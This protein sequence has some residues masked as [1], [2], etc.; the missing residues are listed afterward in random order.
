MAMDEDLLELA[1]AAAAFVAAH[2][3]PA[4][5]D[6]RRAM[7]AAVGAVPFRV[8]YSL[9][10]AGLLMWLIAAYAGAPFVEI[11]R[12]PMALLHLPLTL[13]L[14]ACVLLVA[15]F[16]AAPMKNLIVEWADADKPLPGIVKVARH[17]V[18]A[19]AALWAL[20]HMLA[21]PDF[22][23]WILFGSL[24]A[25]SVLGAVHIDR[26]RRSEGGPAWRRLEAETGN[27]PGAALI[28][29]KARMTLFEIGW[30]RIVGGV[31]L[32]IAMLAAH[33]YVIGVSPLPLPD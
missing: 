9:I 5:G 13:M 33:S 6:L 8:G 28:A 31:A 27:I 29:G 17:P 14:P 25:L 26:R 15:G 12:P 7:I 32:Y 1:V 23:S 21:N 2:M 30:P 18:L 3:I 24:L 16:G 11:F 22:A 4:H 20:T 10:S 19:G